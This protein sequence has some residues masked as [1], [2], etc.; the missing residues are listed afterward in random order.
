VTGSW[1]LGSTQCRA[2]ATRDHL[3]TLSPTTR[4]HSSTKGAR[5]VPTKLAGDKFQRWHSVQHQPAPGNHTGWS[6]SH[7]TQVPINVLCDGSSC[8]QKSEADY[9]R[10]AQKGRRIPDGRA[11]SAARS[12]GVGVAV[13]SGG[14]DFFS[15]SCSRPSP[16]K[17]SGRGAAQRT[18]IGE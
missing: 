2:P 3:R 6:V 15:E 9:E 5:V 16:P 4:D 11:T 13:P 7:P 1:S 17:S 8:P 18:K 14:P 10:A 12:S